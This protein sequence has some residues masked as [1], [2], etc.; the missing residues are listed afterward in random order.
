MTKLRKHIFARA[1]N[2]WAIKLDE[3]W[4]SGKRLIIC[5]NSNIHAH[6]ISLWPFI[7]HMWGNIRPSGNLKEYLITAEKSPEYP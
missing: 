6:T 1:D 5:Y 4:K 3:I 2:T 7:K